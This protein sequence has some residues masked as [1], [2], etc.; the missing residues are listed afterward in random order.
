MNILIFNFEYPPLGGGGGVATA[1]FAHELAKTHTVHVI[2]T[3]F[4]DLPSEEVDHGVFVHRVRV[5]GR[6]SLPTATLFSLLMYVPMA[7]LRALPLCRE[8]A[9]DVLNAQFVVPSGLP[10]W[11]IS[12]FFNI[13]L[14]IS[15]IGGDVYDPSK[16]MS[17]HRHFLLR[18]LIKFLSSKAQGLTAISEDTKSRVI[19]YHRVTKD[20]VV[21]PLGYVPREVAYF[22][23]AELGLPENTPTAVTIGRLI[24]RENYPVLLNAWKNIDN[25]HLV[26]IGDGPIKAELESMIADLGLQDKVHMVG[27]VSEDKKLQYLAGA[28]VF[29]SGAQHE[30][31]GIVFLEAM[32]QG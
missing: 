22:S 13:P 11:F 15:F 18:Y 28:D 9:F 24:P 7:I 23:S 27:F 20:I 12:W 21:C 14:V 31:F 17:P 3:G 19:E 30:G 26:I 25:G 8:L 5:L 29:V 6:F 2:T 32:S 1:Q 10:A 4:K 16:I